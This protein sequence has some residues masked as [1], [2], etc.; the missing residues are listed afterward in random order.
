MYG[1]L[2]RVN[3]TRIRF[4]ECVPIW[5]IETVHERDDVILLVKYRF[6]M[7]Y[8]HTYARNQMF[9]ILLLGKFVY[10][11]KTSLSFFLLIDWLIL[12]DDLIY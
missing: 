5:Y 4:S 2:N 10:D 8:H 11:N 6:F 12:W 1:K 3:A 7:R 9:W